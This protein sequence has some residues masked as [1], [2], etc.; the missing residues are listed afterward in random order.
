ME[1]PCRWPGLQEGTASQGTRRLIGW[2]RH[3]TS[4]DQR[5]WRSVRPGRRFLEFDRRPGGAQPRST[6]SAQLCGPSSSRTYQEILCNC[7]CE[8]YRMLQLLSPAH[9]LAASS[10]ALH[11]FSAPGFHRR[12]ACAWCVRSASPT[13]S[14]RITSASPCTRPSPPAAAGM[15]F[16]SF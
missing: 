4:R 16:R 12:H 3:A 1:R 9:G 5:I 10:P 14:R 13:I 7:A 6:V 15:S 2:F 8:S 11:R